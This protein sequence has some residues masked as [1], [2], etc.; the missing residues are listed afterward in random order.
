[1]GDS[2]STDVECIAR[3]KTGDGQA[4]RQ[5]VERYEGQV[6]ATVV[7]MLGSGA[8]AEDVGQE[9]FIR[10]YESLDKFRGDSAVGTYLT[11]IAINLSLNAVERR[12]RMRWRFWS[13]DEAEDPPEY[14]GVD[15]REERSRQEQSES[16]HAALQQLD[17][18]FRAVVVLRMLEGYSTKETADLLDVA[19][20]TVLSRLSRAIKKLEEVFKK[21]GDLSYER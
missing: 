7:G 10:F 5:L 21:E 2:L 20:G 4:F 18:A 17:P 14:V 11:R 15:G 9:V 3:T 12:K 19:E 13:R 6:A 1:M 16:V 8:E